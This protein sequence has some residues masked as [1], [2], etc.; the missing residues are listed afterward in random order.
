MPERARVSF[1]AC[2][3]GLGVP[4]EKGQWGLCVPQCGARRRGTAQTL[5]PSPVAHLCPPCPVLPAELTPSLLFLCS[6]I[7]SHPISIF[8]LWPGKGLAF[9][10]GGR[11]GWAAQLHF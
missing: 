8:T 3:Q 9:W 2:G 1:A 5:L 7:S 10:G 6:G 4:G 11:A